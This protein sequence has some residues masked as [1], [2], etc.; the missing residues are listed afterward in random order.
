[1]RRATR[2]KPIAARIL[3]PSLVLLLAAVCTTSIPRASAQIT[4]ESP[5]PGYPPSGCDYDQ[6]GNYYCWGNRA[7]TTTTSVN[8]YAVIAISAATLHL[9]TSQGQTSQN[10]AEQLALSNCGKLASD[11]KL[12]MWGINSCVALA[13]SAPDQAWGSSWN[14]NRAQAGASATT[15][16][17]QHG[18]KSCTVQASPCANDDPFRAALPPLDPIVGCYRWFNGADVLIRDNH[19]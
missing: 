13:L 2:T 7:T 15:I 11:C 19:T 6:R 1:M 4:N 14:D 16:C 18:G 5:P 8:R 17:R 3:H 9:G 10:T 12:A